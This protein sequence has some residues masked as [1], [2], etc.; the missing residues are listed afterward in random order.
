[1]QFEKVGMSVSSVRVPEHIIR[2]HRSISDDALRE[3]A[4]SIRN[5][6][7][8]DPAEVTNTDPDEVA[9]VLKTDLRDH[10]T[11]RLENDRHIIVPWLDAARPLNGLRIL[12]VGC[13]TGSSTVALGEQGANLFGLDINEGALTVARDRCAAYGILAEFLLGNAETSLQKFQVGQFDMIIFFA[14]L[15]H[16]TIGERLRALNSAWAILPSRGLLVIVETPNRLWFYDSHTAFLPFYHWLPYEL[17][18]RYTRLS[19]RPIF[20]SRYETYD[21]DSK[22]KFVREGLGMSYHELDLAI[23]PAEGLQIVS[24]LRSFNPAWNIPSETGR[25]Y[26]NAL[27]QIRPDLHKGFFEEYL[28]LVISKP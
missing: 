16:M 14:S 26:Q 1:M 17:A 23:A 21:A 15:E 13:G 27:I 5:N 3:I 19:P 9:E 6:Y 28:D 10:L 2:N 22:L 24:S 25:A 18:F 12:E 7:Q 20:R 8:L 11:H 4:L